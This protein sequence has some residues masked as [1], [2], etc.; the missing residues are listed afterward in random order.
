MISF[1]VVFFGNCTGRFVLDITGNPEGRFPHDAAQIVQEISIYLFMPEAYA[2]DMN[3]LGSRRLH[4]CKFLY[5]S[6]VTCQE[7]P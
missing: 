2:V 4:I 1:F 7:Q 5:L 6:C 3:I